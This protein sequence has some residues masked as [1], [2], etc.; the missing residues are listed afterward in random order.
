MSYSTGQSPHVKST[1]DRSSNV[2]QLGSLDK[3]G[4]HYFYTNNL[5]S[6]GN[7]K[8]SSADDSR[9]AW[10]LKDVAEKLRRKRKRL[11]ANHPY[12]TAKFKFHKSS[13]STDRQ[14]NTTPVNNLPTKAPPDGS[15]G[16]SASTRAE[17]RLDAP[18]LKIKEGSSWEIYDKVYQL[19]LSE[20]VTIAER[21]RS[22]SELMMIRELSVLNNWCHALDTSSDTR[23]V[24][25]ELCWDFLLWECFACNF[26][27][28]DD[29]PP[30]DRSSISIF[31][32]ESDDDNH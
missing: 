25:C 6:S 28:H 30:S 11:I 13:F 5:P 22:V 20:L 15:H 16:A 19:E 3:K 17:V 9:Y 32:W 14:T 21:R 12:E 24:F 4:S 2:T 1:T 7:T 29:V 10:A 8:D 31:E 18:S 27:I 23:Q 26:E